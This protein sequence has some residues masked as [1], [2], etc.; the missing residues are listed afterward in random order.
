MSASRALPVR[1]VAVAALAALSVAGL[2][3]SLTDTAPWYRALVKPVWTPPDL[4]FGVIWTI[5]F[6]LAAI[7]GVTAWRAATDRAAREWVLG[8][9]AL[10]GFL[11]VFWSLLF[12]R[13][14]RPDFAL[15]E[16]APFWGSVGV[17]IALL[18]PISRKA[19]WLLAPY[20]AWVT[21]AGL[22]N[23]QIVHWN[24]PFGAA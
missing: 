11:N 15:L 24:S 1:A 17:L 18:W 19:S 13:L 23:Y 5:I 12:F 3:G 16:V 21:L 10:N 20:L 4:A 8:L 2:G 22:M 14:Q 9:F 6:A 7:S